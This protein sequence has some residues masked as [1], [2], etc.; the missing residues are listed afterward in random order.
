MPAREL[1]PHRRAYL[2]YE[3]KIAGDRGEVRRWDSG[4]AR[5]EAWTDR[6]VRLRLAGN[7]LVGM[8]DLRLDPGEADA[9]GPRA[10][11][12]RFGKLS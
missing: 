11:R 7:Q 3:G 6:V 10:W 1:P 8:V 5:V 4:R 9:E 12:F 2:D